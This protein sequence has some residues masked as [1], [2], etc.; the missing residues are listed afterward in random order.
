VLKGI[1]HKDCFERSVWE[2]NLIGITK[3]DIG[4]LLLG[5][6]NCQWFVV[7]ALNIQNGGN[8]TVSSA[9]IKN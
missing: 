5:E 4:S 1:C 8:E 7:D 2:G 6:F 9:D 3:D